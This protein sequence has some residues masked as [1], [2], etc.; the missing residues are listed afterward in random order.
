[1]SNVDTLAGPHRSPPSV[2]DIDA[3]SF[4]NE[5]A[6]GREIIEGLK[7]SGGCVVRGFVAKEDIERLG[8]DFAPHFAKAKPLISMKTIKI[9]Q[10][11][12]ERHWI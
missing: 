4:A 10:F 6:L 9:S 11:T 12:I 5:H 7:V 3:A 1:M 2:S 8:Q